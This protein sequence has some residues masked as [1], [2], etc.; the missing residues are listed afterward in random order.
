MPVSRHKNGYFK[1]ACVLL[2]VTLLSCTIQVTSLL[3]LCHWS[4][5][6]RERELEEEVGSESD[7]QTI[8]VRCH[9]PFES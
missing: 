3:I 5:Y 7:H 1:L 6:I 4:I 9:G 8:P 2:Y